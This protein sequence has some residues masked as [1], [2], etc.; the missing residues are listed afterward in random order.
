MYEADRVRWDPVDSVRLRYKHHA[1][2][3]R[4]E[5]NERIL[6]LATGYSEVVDTAI[7][8]IRDANDEIRDV[9]S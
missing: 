2:T 6:R 4:A 5:M 8:D 1:V 9:F 7:S 3:C